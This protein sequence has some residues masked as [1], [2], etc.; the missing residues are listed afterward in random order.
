MWGL[1]PGESRWVITLL[2]L[3]MKKNVSFGKKKMKGEL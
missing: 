2:T 3:E 1:I